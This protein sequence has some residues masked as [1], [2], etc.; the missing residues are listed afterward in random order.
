MLLPSKHYQSWYTV[1]PFHKQKICTF[2][3]PDL[4]EVNAHKIECKLK[5]ILLYA[6]T[7]FY[8]TT[9]EIWTSFGAATAEFS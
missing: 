6:I 7:A 5:Y 8:C 4:Q 3:D 2:C 9:Q 1:Q